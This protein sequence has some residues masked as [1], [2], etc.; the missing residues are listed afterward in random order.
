MAVSIV[1]IVDLV[2]VLDLADRAYDVHQGRDRPPHWR[3][4]STPASTS[5]DSALRRMRVAWWSRRNRFPSVAVG[6]VALELGDEAELAGDQVLVAAGQVHERWPR[7]GAA[8]P[9]PPPPGGRL[10]HVEGVGHVG[11]LVAGAHLDRRHVMDLDVSP[12]GVSRTFRTAAGRRRSAMAIDWCVSC[13]RGRTMDRDTNRIGIA[14]AAITTSAVPRYHRL[15]V[16]GC[17]VQFV[18]TLGGCPTRRR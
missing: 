8:W 9:G 12:T 15:R 18:G 16:L 4:A 14:A 17:G 3:G 1:V 13:L 10:H 5:S 6:L 2:I 7:C 11:H